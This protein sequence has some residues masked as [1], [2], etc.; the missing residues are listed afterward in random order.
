MVQP[1][2][3]S[4][5]TFFVRDQTSFVAEPEILGVEMGI[6]IEVV[7]GYNIDYSYIVHIFR[8]ERGV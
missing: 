3:G 1:Q 6:D 8:G 4:G 5:L 2:K 7:F